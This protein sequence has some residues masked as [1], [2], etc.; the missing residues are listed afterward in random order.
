MENLA[1]GDVMGREQHE[2][3]TDHEIEEYGIIWNLE[4]EETAPWNSFDLLF[5]CSEPY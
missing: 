5:S 2:V 1:V 4:L 3:S